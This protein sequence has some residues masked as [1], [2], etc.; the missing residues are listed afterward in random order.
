MPPCFAQRHAR[1]QG[2]LAV[3]LPG[4]GA[5]SPV[6]NEGGSSLRF[7]SLL[8]VEVGADVDVALL[9]LFFASLAR[10]RNTTLTKDLTSTTMCTAEAV[11]T[12]TLQPWLGVGLRGRRCAQQGANLVVLAYDC[13]EDLAR[14]PD[15]LCV[16][17]HLLAPDTTRSVPCRAA[18]LTPRGPVE[19]MRAQVAALREEPRRAAFEARQ[20]PQYEA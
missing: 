2:T 15:L 11:W 19:N 4:R 6:H 20:A 14:V 8:V 10:P 3:R 12:G 7:P 13:I 5:K 1:R 9:G 18:S 17:L 16:M